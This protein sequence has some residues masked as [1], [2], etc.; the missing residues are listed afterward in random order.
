MVR[1][2]ADHCYFV[3]Q[4]ILKKVGI[5]NK[6]IAWIFIFIKCLLNDHFVFSSVLKYS[7]AL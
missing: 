1:G 2:F 5:V 4:Y 6:Q 3:F 7:K